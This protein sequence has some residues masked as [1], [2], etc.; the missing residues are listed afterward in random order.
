M[1]ED[2]QFGKIIV[3]GRPYTSDII[4]FGDTVWSKW[5]RNQGHELCI[6]DIKYAVDDF[7]P[8]VV[9]VGTGR[10]GMMKVLQET[11]SFLESRSIQLIIKKTAKACK[12]FNNL[13]NSEKVLGAFHLTC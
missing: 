12:T 5:W 10:F 4:I 2:Y 11:V 13:A 7:D 9:V 6:S 3:N 8:T 1:I